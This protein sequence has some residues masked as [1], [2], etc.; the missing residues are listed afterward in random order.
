MPML[1]ICESCSDSYSTS[2]KRQKF[3]GECQVLRDTRVRAWFFRQATACAEC[4]TATY[5]IRSDWKI[6][7]ACARPAELPAPAPACAH[8]DKRHRIA[9]GMKNTCVRCIQQA[10]EWRDAYIK[11]LRERFKA[12]IAAQTDARPT[13]TAPLKAFE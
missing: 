8:C 5:P 11:K 13:G 7:A 6:C 2:W 1:K 4:A 3:C 9:P 10:P 12:K